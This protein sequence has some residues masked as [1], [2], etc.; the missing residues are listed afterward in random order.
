MKNWEM[1]PAEETESIGQKV[2][3]PGELHL[4]NVI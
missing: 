4:V 2:L 3:Y 1:R